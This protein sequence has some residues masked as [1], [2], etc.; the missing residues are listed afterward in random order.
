M[1]LMLRVVGRAFGFE[2]VSGFMSGIKWVCMRGY[3]LWLGPG[4]PLSGVA[5][6]V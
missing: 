1:S 4:R 2:E 5:E 6:F 3:E